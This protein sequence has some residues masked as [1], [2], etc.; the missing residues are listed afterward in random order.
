MKKVSVGLITCGRWH[1]EP[2]DFLK[3]KKFSVKLYDKNKK[4][5]FKGNIRNI[6]IY[7]DHRI[8]INNQF[9]W[10]PINDFGSVKADNLNYKSKKFKIRSMVNIDYGFDK[11]KILHLLEKNKIPIP[12]KPSKKAIGILKSRYGS[13]SRG[14]FLKKY[15]SY[16][17]KKYIFQE[18]IKGIELSV[19]TS[20]HNGKHRLMAISYRHM[21]NF[22]TAS[23]I[24]SFGYLKSLNFFLKRKISRI[25][26]A[27]K[28]K[29]GVSHIEV[30]ITSEKKFYP[31]DI[32]IRCAG[33]AVASVF[34]PMILKTN[35]IQEDFCLMTGNKN[36]KIF[37][38][39]IPGCIIYSSNQKN[40]FN[41]KNLR[42]F[43][44]KNDYYEKL[45]GDVKPSLKGSDSD[46]KQILAFKT[47]N[48][49]K[50]FSRLKEIFK[51]EEFELIKKNY[52]F[53]NNF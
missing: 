53:L 43:V 29:N 34:L 11:L 9:F 1:K 47:I 10:S 5:Y 39:Q 42:M 41:K 8:D 25:L 15:S 2:Y 24:I 26:D 19:E 46:R 28:V 27:V 33:A 21:L 3:K 23:S 37:K 30:I 51:D 13:G 7:K 20:S 50:L 40:N 32:N 16:D 36:S 6:K 14:V 31:I 48:T 52:E 22:K 17:K 44:Y 45:N 38:K 12:S 4:N 49:K 35:I 18:Y